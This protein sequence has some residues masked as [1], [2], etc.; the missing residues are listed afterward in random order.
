MKTDFTLSSEN[1][2]WMQGRNLISSAFL[3]VVFFM[4]GYILFGYVSAGDFANVE[5][6][7]IHADR[8]I[9]YLSPLFTIAAIYFGVQLKRALGKLFSLEKLKLSWLDR[10][11][12]AGLVLTMIYCVVNLQTLYPEA[13][14]PHITASFWIYGISFFLTAVFITRNPEERKLYEDEDTIALRVSTFS[15]QD[16]YCNLTI[17]AHRLIMNIVSS[18]YLVGVLV[19]IGMNM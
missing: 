8:K 6:P 19:V 1:S 17:S 14:T 11:Q 7:S 5:N 9:A 2:G 10:I 4:V 13:S 15:T 16:V 3:L 18:L 12:L